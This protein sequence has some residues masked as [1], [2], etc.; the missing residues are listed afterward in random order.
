MQRQRQRQRQTIPMPKA[1]SPTTHSRSY[2]ATWRWEF[3]FGRRTTNRHPSNP[4]GRNLRR[5]CRQMLPH[6]HRHRLP[7]LSMDP[8]RIRRTSSRVY[9]SATPA[10]PDTGTPPRTASGWHSRQRRRNHRPILVL[11]M[12]PVLL[13]LLP[14]PRP[15]TR[16]G[17]P[18]SASPWPRPCP[19]RK[20]ERAIPPWPRH[21]PRP[22]R[23]PNRPTRTGRSRAFSSRSS[24]IHNTQYVRATYISYS[25]DTV[26]CDIVRCGTVDV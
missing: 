10:T 19:R 7:P 11:V 24:K 3:P 9:C 2:G 6:R 20:R 26:W 1:A 8:G 12:V 22:R 4:D 18:S 21:R 14:L 5:Y 17:S 16:D 23:I 13:L 25:Y 15:E